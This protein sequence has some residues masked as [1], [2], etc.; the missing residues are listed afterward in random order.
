M[1]KTVSLLLV[2]VLCVLLCAC[3]APATQNTYPNTSP[4]TTTRP[5]TNYPNTTQPSTNSGN[6]NNSSQ[7]N[8]TQKPSN[9]TNPPSTPAAKDPNGFNTPEELVFSYIRTKTSII[10]KEE[11]R[12]H[13]TEV[14]WPHIL[15]EKNKTFEELYQNYVTTMQPQVE[16]FRDLYGTDYAVGFNIT[17]ITNK[18]EPIENNEENNKAALEYFGVNCNEIEN[19]E[20]T[21]SMTI[22]GSL[23]EKTVS[24]MLIVRKIADKWYSY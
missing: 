17:S 15:R 2:V 10:S 7:N 24:Q 21:F 16:T 8:N 4:N 18:T 1:K 5:T 20:I 12:K 23:S 6:S 3:G 9:S 13:Y 19:Y 22:S 11:Y 14:S